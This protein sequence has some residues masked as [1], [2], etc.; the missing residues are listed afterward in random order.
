MNIFSLL[1][2]QYFV[3]DD[4][5]FLTFD[6]SKSFF[7]KTIITLTITPFIEEIAFRWGIIYNYKLNSFFIAATTFITSLSFFI[8]NEIIILKLLFISIIIY[9][10]FFFVLRFLYDKLSFRKDSLVIFFS[11]LSLILFTFS[12]VDNFKFYEGNIFYILL[13]SIFIHGVIYTFIRLK[14]GLFFS[15]FAHYTFNIINFIFYYYSLY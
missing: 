4:D 10:I 15:I 2:F 12:H 8:L 9:I 3:P 11:S 14:Y 7:F 6:D 13:F 1:I 5:S